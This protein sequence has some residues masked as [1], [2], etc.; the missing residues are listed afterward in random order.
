MCVGQG[1]RGEGHTLQ[2]AKEG[3]GPPIDGTVVIEVPRSRAAEVGEHRTHV[4]TVD[5]AVAVEIGG[6]AS[7]VRGV[8]CMGSSLWGSGSCL[9]L[10]LGEPAGVQESKEDV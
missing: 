2:A 9:G 10:K 8:V 4:R 6:I 5:R 1:F 7:G 3:Q